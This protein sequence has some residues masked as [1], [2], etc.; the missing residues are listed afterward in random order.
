MELTHEGKIPPPWFATLEHLDD[1]WSEER[2]KHSGEYRVVLACWKCNNQRNTNRELNVPIEERR[3]RA[4]NGRT[5]KS[6]DQ[7]VPQE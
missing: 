2:G 5:S 4:E 1:K 7:R 3:R 6:Y